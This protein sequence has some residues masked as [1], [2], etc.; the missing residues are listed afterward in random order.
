MAEE[1]VKCPSCGAEFLKITAERTGG[2]CLPCHNGTRNGVAYRREVAEK[3]R[4][5]ALDSQDETEV[6]SRATSSESL[7]HNPKRS[8]LPAGC[9]FALLI[10]GFFVWKPLLA[11]LAGLIAKLVFQASWDAAIVVAVVTYVILGGL[12]MLLGLIDDTSE[13]V[14]NWRT[15]K[16]DKRPNIDN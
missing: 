11:V 7:R 12:W 16:R 2:E 9:W 4:E 10:A 8:T 14:H 3:E 1:K 5:A 13:I 15:R 6:S